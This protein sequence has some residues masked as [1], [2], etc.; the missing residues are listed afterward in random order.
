M[1][2][3]GTHPVLDRGLFW[4]KALDVWVSRVSSMLP[5]TSWNSLAQPVNTWQ[6]NRL[7]G[8]D[9]VSKTFGLLW[10]LRC[11]AGMDEEQS[12]C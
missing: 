6:R 5:E 7:G 4:V 10:V 9:G 12:G 11:G 1:H 8:R 3:Y 2:S